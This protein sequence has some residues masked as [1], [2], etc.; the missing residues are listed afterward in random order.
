M[1]MKG[2]KKIRKGK[3]ITIQRGSSFSW[4]VC[5]STASPMPNSAGGDARVPT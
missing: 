3:L 4:T 1:A 5:G 2:F